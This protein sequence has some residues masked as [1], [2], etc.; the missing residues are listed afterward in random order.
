MFVNQNAAPR[1]AGFAG[2]C[3]ALRLKSRARGAALR[4]IR[5]NGIKIR[6]AE[7]LA[8]AAFLK[9]VRACVPPVRVWLCVYASVHIDRTKP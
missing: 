1:S 4:Y 7:Q 2:K 3:C 8:T 6:A 9:L 5:H